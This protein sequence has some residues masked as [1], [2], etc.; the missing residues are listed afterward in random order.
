MQ[1]KTP[2]LTRAECSA[3]RGIAIIG[4]FLH[5]Y[6]HWLGFAVKENEYTFTIA[7]CRS[8][9]SAL[10]SPDINLP[11]HLVSFFGHYGVPIFLFL[12]AYGLVMKYEQRLPASARQE[13]T[14]KFI[15]HHY[16]KLFKMM[17]VGFVAFTMVDAI[18]PGAHKYSVAA[19]LGQLFMFNNMM[20]D[21][22]H[23]I[24]P[25]PYWFFGL[26][27]QLY[28]VYRLLLHRRSS[29]VTVALIVVCWAAQEMCAPESEE[30][31][32]VRYNFM[33]GMLP[34]GVGLLYARHGRHLTHAFWLV[35]TVL[36]GMAVFF[37]SFNY[38]LWLWAPLFVC[39]FAVGLVKLTPQRVCGWAAWVGG[40][41]AAIFV[42]H[43]VTRKV[44]IPISRHGDVY[45]GLLL[46][47]VASVALAW[48]YH[49]SKALFA[50]K[51]KAAKAQ[52]KK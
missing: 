12:S 4:I 14:L 24:W 29:W 21:P 39:S 2:L 32:R 41:S 3:L 49:E 31:N 42:L 5:N 47:I 46:Y 18:T 9:A 52:E 20:P 27:M 33:G 1:T 43:P 35:E 16:T 44:F 45:T 11:V 22:D 10:A 25:G 30:L 13:S 50:N 15:G 51:S 6:C 40:I 48:F 23:V 26:M 37:F 19:V 34:F 28:I 36:S 8:L 7:K 17:I 38:Q